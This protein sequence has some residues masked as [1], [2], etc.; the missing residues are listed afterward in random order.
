MSK[1]NTMTIVCGTY[2]NADKRSTISYI[3]SNVTLAMLIVLTH[4]YYRCIF[5]R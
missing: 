2:N 1:H 4:T 3:L 5:Q